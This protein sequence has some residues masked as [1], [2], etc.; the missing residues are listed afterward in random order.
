MPTLNDAAANAQADNIGADYATATLTIYD[1]VVPANADAALSGN[2]A[3]VT[4][5]LAGFGAAVGGVITANAIA[6]QTIA[7]SGTATFARL[8]ATGK[9]MQLSVGTSGS[10]A[11]VI[12]SSTNFIAGNPSDITSLQITQPKA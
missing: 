12:V 5:T 10:G 6:S 3:L 11:E 4:H 8:E 9:I 1:G 7:N 2:T